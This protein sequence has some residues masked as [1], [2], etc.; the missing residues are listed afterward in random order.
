M[1]SVQQDELGSS[2][3]T[4]LMVLGDDSTFRQFS[5]YLDSITL[6]SYS[7]GKQCHQSI[8]NPKVH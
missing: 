4:R 7:R 2:F 8:T 3:V 1:I 6:Q 5:S